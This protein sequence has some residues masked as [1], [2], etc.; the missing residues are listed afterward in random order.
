MATAYRMQAV[1]SAEP[2]GLDPIAAALRARVSL[3]GR[4]LRRLSMR[5]L[6][7]RV[8][9]IRSTARVHD[10]PAAAGIAAGLSDAIA[11]D[12]RAA[13]IHPY[14]DALREACGC[15]RGD[16]AATQALLASISVR[17]AD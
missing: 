5:E 11:R 10:L 14:L 4:D 15:A 7:G 1:S 2:V 8:D 9:E 13:L 16:A 12:G 17:L 6:C 3:I